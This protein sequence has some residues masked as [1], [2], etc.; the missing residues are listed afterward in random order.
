LIPVPKSPKYKEPRKEDDWRP[1]P[2]DREKILATMKRWKTER[3]EY[4]NWIVCP[5]RNRERIWA[6]SEPKI[7]GILRNLKVFSLPEQLEIFYELN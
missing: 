1:G 4:P 3:E 6:D 5:R 7:L 2:V